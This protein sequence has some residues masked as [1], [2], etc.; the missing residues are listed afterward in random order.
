MKTLSLSR[1]LYSFPST[2]HGID[3]TICLE[4]R[5]FLGGEGGKF[6]TQT[7]WIHKRSLEIGNRTGGIV[8]IGIPCPLFAISVRWRLS[9]TKPRGER[10]SFSAS[11]EPLQHSRSP[12]LSGWSRP[13]IRPMNL[14]ECSPPCLLYPLRFASS[15]R[16]FLLPLFS[17]RCPCIRPEPKKRLFEFLLRSKH[18]CLFV[19][20]SREM[21]RPC[22]S[23]L[24]IYGICV[25]R[26]YVD[27]RCYSR[28]MRPPS[29]CRYVFIIGGEDNA[30]FFF[31]FLG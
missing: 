6:L 27:R 13:S 15:L 26:G 30:G 9:L 8:F 1:F 17:I 12:P 23:L 5:V 11:R 24:T 18:R 16:L 22:R 2:T 4:N 21:D 31:F 10:H 25:T 14:Y 29:L 3:S 20:L 7:P 28:V 19:R